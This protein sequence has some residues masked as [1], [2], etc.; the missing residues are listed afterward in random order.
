MGTYCY[1]QD[2][3]GSTSFFP[4]NKINS[5]LQYNLFIAHQNEHS[6]TID[7]FSDK[8]ICFHF[9]RNRY[10]LWL[11]HHLSISIKYINE[12]SYENQP[13]LSHAIA[14]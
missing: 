12:I 14:S 1:R 5:N 11:Y 2:N 3:Y 10:H 7:K 6:H 13:Y 8:K 4:N 9:I